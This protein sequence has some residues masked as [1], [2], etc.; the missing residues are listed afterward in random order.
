MAP[1]HLKYRDQS[2][3]QSRGSR[4]LEFSRDDDYEATGDQN[5]AE[6]IEESTDQ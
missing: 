5:H 6:A 1:G 2:S 4:S 3:E